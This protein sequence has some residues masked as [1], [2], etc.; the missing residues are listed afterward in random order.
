MIVG[1][2]NTDQD[3]N[4][5][6]DATKN[7]N[8]DA[9]QDANIGGGSDWRQGLDEPTKQLLESKGIKDIPALVKN[10]REAQDFIGRKGVIKPKDDTDK[11]GWDRWYKEAGRPDEAGAYKMPELKLPDKAKALFNDSKLSEFKKIAHEQGLSQKQFD[12]VVKNY[13]TSVVSEL[14]VVLNLE[15]QKRVSAE[16]TLRQEWGSAFESRKQFAQNVLKEYGGGVSDDILAKYGNDPDIIRIL[17]NVGSKLGDDTLVRGGSVSL[18]MTPA[19][20]QERITEIM[21]DKDGP[22]YNA[23]GFTQEQRKM[24]L[25]ELSR[26][27]TIRNGKK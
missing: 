20:A 10:Y 6:T 25:T 13:L 12:G 21:S 24:V 23:A 14:E 26:L 16:N 1:D 8:Q 9:N 11:E 27:Y 17:A 18:G 15:E 4:Q 5:N 22:L 19:E 7:T 3:K 2:T